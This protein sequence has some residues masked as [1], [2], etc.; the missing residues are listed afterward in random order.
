MMKNMKW[1]LA[2]VLVSILV[3]G[4]TAGA[5]DTVKIG[6]M[7]PLTGFAAADGL[8][9]HYS[10]KL[11]VERINKEG[12]VL[13]KK[14]EL[15]VY[16]DRADGKEAVALARKL[17]QQDRV[18]AVVGADGAD[19]VG[20][21]VVGRAWRWNRASG[22]VLGVRSSRQPA[23]RAPCRGLGRSQRGRR[24]GRVRRR[25]AD[26]VVRGPGV[27]DRL[28]AVVAGSRTDSV[29]AVG[30]GRTTRSRHRF[31]RRGGAVAVR[32]VEFRSCGAR[33]GGRRRRRQHRA[34]S[35]VNGLAGVL[36]H[37]GADEPRPDAAPRPATGPLPAGSGRSDP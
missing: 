36:G 25:L 7:A 35:L 1:L 12:G 33:A 11:A 3:W 13:G 19:Q 29:P 30:V 32:A 9:V 23:A 27:R 16:D 24:G 20:A 21:F 34:V 37:P 10:V 2:V 22:E 4:G 31:L 6:L 26:R 18:A 28:V 15:V 14:V 5:A 17:I 8:S